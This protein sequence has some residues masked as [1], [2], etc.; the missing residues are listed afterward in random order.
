MYLRTKRVRTMEINDINNLPLLIE[1]SQL[2]M[3]KGVE[4]VSRAGVELIKSIRDNEL[5]SLKKFQMVLEEAESDA[6]TKIINNL[7][8]VLPSND[9]EILNICA[10]HIKSLDIIVTASVNLKK[11]DMPQ[12]LRTKIDHFKEGCINDYNKEHWEKLE[13]LIYRI[14]NS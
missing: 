4:I 1:I 6:I 5:D 3:T 2:L 13:R 10:S 8:T 7:L 12:S 11:T 9:Q 14:Y